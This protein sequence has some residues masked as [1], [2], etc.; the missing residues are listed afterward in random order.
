MPINFALKSLRSRSKAAKFILARGLPLGPTA[1][2]F[3]RCSVAYPVLHL[4]DAPDGIDNATKLDDDAV[5]VR[6]TTRP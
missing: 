5:A 6:F 1:L 3:S 4:D 2:S